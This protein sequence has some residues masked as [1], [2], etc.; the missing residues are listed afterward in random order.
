MMLSEINKEKLTL[1]SP[2]YVKQLSK[3]LKIAKEKILLLILSDDIIVPLNAD[4]M[5]V[6]GE[7]IQIVSISL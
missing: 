2:P 6:I 7:K 1:I 3:L 4:I 5:N